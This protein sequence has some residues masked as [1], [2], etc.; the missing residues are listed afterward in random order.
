MILIFLNKSIMSKTNNRK[1]FNAGIF[2]HLR[3][4]HLINKKYGE[5]SIIIDTNVKITALGYLLLF[6]ITQKRHLCGNHVNKKYS[7][8]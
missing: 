8:Y 5:I 3:E 7:K 1:K 4:N 2:Y 6:K